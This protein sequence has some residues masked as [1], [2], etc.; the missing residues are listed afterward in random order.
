MAITPTQQLNG[1]VTLATTLQVSKYYGQSTLEWQNGHIV[2]I[3][4]SQTL[5]L[6]HVNHAQDQKAKDKDS[7]AL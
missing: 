3:R 4:L 7:R 2:L 6:D 1:L 5:K